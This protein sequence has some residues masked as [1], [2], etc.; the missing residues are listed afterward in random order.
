VLKD[1]GREDVRTAESD[2]FFI[3]PSR[4][5]FITEIHRKAD[6]YKLNQKVLT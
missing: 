5:G 2:D 6:D 3:R 4:V 1:R